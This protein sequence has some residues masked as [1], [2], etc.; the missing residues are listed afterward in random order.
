MTRLGLHAKGDPLGLRAAMATNLRMWLKLV[1]EVARGRIAEARKHAVQ[2]RAQR[3]KPAQDPEGA[4]F[5]TRDNGWPVE[6]EKVHILVEGILTDGGDVGHATVSGKAAICE[7]VAWNAR[8][9]C[10]NIVCARTG[11]RARAWACGDSVGSRHGASINLTLTLAHA[12]M[13]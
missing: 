10:R 8:H 7:R 1:E 3:A 4:F 9:A 11:A 12:P 5:D 6:R 13:L 2:A